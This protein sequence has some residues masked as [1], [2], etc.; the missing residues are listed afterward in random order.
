MGP[1]ITPIVSHAGLYGV[2]LPN[3]WL[4]VSSA[5]HDKS[6]LT[7]VVMLMWFSTLGG[8]AMG[9]CIGEVDVEVLPGLGALDSCSSP[10]NCERSTCR[11]VGSLLG[12]LAP[13][14]SDPG[15]DVTT[16]TRVYHLGFWLKKLVDF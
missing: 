15:K 14:A 11:G 6:S 4:E 8:Y 2:E 1:P 9:R 7:L 10:V 12:A 3:G 13:W 5:A 16:G